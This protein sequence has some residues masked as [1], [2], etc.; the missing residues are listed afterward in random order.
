MILGSNWEL[1]P[2]FAALS[3]ATGGSTAN[4][5]ARVSA[6]E[7]LM[8]LGSLLSRC[9]GKA[10]WGMDASPTEYFTRHFTETLSQRCKSRLAYVTAALSTTSRKD[11]CTRL[12]RWWEAGGKNGQLA[13]P[14]APFDFYI[15]ILDNSR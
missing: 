11:L 2:N 14:G 4:N 15:K 12:R 5:I 10:M 7:K 1:D 9:A 3:F 6:E 13:L 8:P